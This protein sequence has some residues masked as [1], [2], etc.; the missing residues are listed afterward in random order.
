MGGDEFVEPPE[1]RGSD[2]VSCQLGIA[3]R[4]AAGFTPPL[5]TRVEMPP[6]SV[7][8]VTPLKLI[9]RGLFCKHNATARRRLKRHSVCRI[10]FE[11]ALFMI[12]Y[13]CSSSRLG[14]LFIPLCVF[15][16][17]LTSFLS[18]RGV[19]LRLLQGDPN[20][21]KMP[22]RGWGATGLVVFAGTH[23][24]DCVCL[25]STAHLLYGYHTG[26]NG[27]YWVVLL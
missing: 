18:K 15:V 2:R 19:A 9:S 12:S 1:E 22:A 5:S 3:C 27:Y 16:F 21:Q 17:L 25:R 23:I 13:L 10:P 24:I 6:L 11:V 20:L 8:K 26:P 4:V 14:A 7:Q